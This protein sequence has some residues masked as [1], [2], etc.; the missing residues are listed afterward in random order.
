MWRRYLIGLF[1]LLFLLSG[2]TLGFLLV[3]ESQDLSSRASLTVV[4]GRVEALGE[5]EA[6]LGYKDLVVE[7]LLGGEKNVLVRYRADKWIVEGAS[8]VNEGDL[9]TLKAVKSGIV[10]DR[11]RLEK[12]LGLNYKIGRFIGRMTSTTGKAEGESWEFEFLQRKVIVQ[13]WEVTLFGEDKVGLIVILPSLDKQP[14]IE[15]ILEKISLVE[16]TIRGVNDDAAGEAV[17]AL[18]RP[19]VVML[20]TTLCNEVTL[21]PAEEGQKFPF[22][23][24]G[25]GTGFFISDQ[26]HIATNGHVVK[27][28]PKSALMSG[29]RNGTLRSLAGRVIGEIEGILAGPEMVS[30]LDELYAQPDTVLRLAFLV[31]NM[32]DEGKLQLREGKYGFYVQLGKTPVV[33]D[34]EWQVNLGEDIVPATL[35]AADYEEMDDLGFR[36][37]DLAI[38]KISREGIYPALELSEAEAGMGSQIQVMGYPGIVSGKGSELLDVS[39]ATV[40]TLTSGIVSAIKEARGDRKKLIQTDAVITRGNS[41]GPAVNGSGKVVG[42]ATYGL[43]DEELGGNYGFLRDVED[44]RVLMEKAGVQRGDNLVYEKWRLGLESFWLNYFG[45]AAED[46]GEVKNLYSLHPTVDLYLKRARAKR[47]T[48]EDK[49]PMFTRSQRQVLMTMSGGVMAASVVGMGGLLMWEWVEKRKRSV[50]VA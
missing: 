19:S 42:I 29:V 20:T 5:I 12:E 15:E 44:L 28:L 26:G 50:L 14:E 49:T 4:G 16:T 27:F 40:P 46:F 24:G 33:I 31:G 36:S 23:V 11:K 1:S 34:S 41:G 13:V 39:S 2:V 3:D 48:T 35:V 9:A 32:Y 30:R 43:V 18:V 8:L 25:S 21:I 45:F 22:C 47:A 7:G 6:V 10:R 38:L 37:S 17:A